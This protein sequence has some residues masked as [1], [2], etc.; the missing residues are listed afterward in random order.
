MRGG[1][2]IRTVLVFALLGA[3]AT[4]FSS[5]AIHGWRHWRVVRAGVL[6]N[7]ILRGIEPL[8]VPKEAP[9]VVAAPP[10]SAHRVVP[11]GRDWAHSIWVVIGRHAQHE[12]AGWRW[13]VFALVG[14]KRFE[15]QGGP[16]PP[17]RLTREHV[18]RIRCGWPAH[19]MTHAS[20]GGSF[21]LVH[22]GLATGPATADAFGR[23]PALSLHGGY[24]PFGWA[25]TQRWPQSV[26][27]AT[28]DP[29]DRFA[30]PLMPIWPGFLLNTFFYALLMFAPA[31]AVRALVRVRRRRRGRCAVCGY[32]RDGLAPRATCPE[33]GEKP[34]PRQEP[35]AAPAS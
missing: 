11:A 35:R 13:E 14:M 1:P 31:R 22:P 2:A 23:T 27:V 21:G 12:R 6:T 25:S 33:C 18:V 8:A 20:Y 29:I 7:D 3:L 16:P 10:W 9:M 34:R 32:D 26:T 19:A 30:L 5:W 17:A 4:V 28:Y 15:A 24:A